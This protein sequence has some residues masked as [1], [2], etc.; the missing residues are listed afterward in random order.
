LPMRRGEPGFPVFRAEHEMVMQREMRRSHVESFQIGWRHAT[1]N[2]RPSRWIGHLAGG[3]KE[4][5]HC[6]FASRQFV[7]EA[8]QKLAGGATTGSAR[9]ITPNRPAP[10][11][12]A[13]RTRGVWRAT[14]PQDI[15][16]LLAPLPGRIP[17][18]RWWGGSVPVVPG[19]S[20]TFTTG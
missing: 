12:G 15:R 20:A 14:S 13:R 8:R 10:W 3:T 9:P 4:A 1:M 2:F 18:R 6:Q 7:P 5:P 17:N 11:K 19:R 16:M